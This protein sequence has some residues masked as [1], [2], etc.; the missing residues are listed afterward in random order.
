MIL[1][2]HIYCWVW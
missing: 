1:S 2:L